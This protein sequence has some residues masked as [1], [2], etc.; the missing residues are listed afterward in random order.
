MFLGAFLIG[1]REGL[2]AALVV[3]ILGAYVLRLGRRD[4]LRRIALGVA[5][6]VAISLALGAILTFGAYGLSFQAQEIIGGT[7]SLVAVGMVTW[8]VFWMMRT[9]RGMKRQLEGQIDARI[10]GPAWGIVLVAVLSVAREGIETALFVW[11]TTRGGAWQPGFFGAIAGIAIA[12]GIA[13]LLMRGL[14]RVN[15][16]KFFTVTGVLLIVMAAGVVAYAI[17]DLQEAAVLP[18]PFMAAP[19][20]L[21]ALAGWF[22]ESAWAFRVSDVIAPDGFLGAVLKGTIGFTP[23]MTK[24]ELVAWAAYLVTTMTFFIRAG[25]A[26]VRAASVAQARKSPVRDA[27]A[28]EAALRPAAS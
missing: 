6:A 20:A 22:G 23:E 9:A 1:L 3:G 4:L 27:A 10:A 28:H 17:H 19:A 2:E 21:P 26:N 8:M 13:W 12:A 11:S 15:L 14:V 18:G 5:I 24:L 7:L 25:R 16:T